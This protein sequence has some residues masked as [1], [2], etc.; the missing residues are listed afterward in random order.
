MV[1]TKQYRGFT[2]HFGP[3]VAGKNGKICRRKHW[4]RWDNFLL[5]LQNLFSPVSFEM[6]FQTKISEDM[7]KI[8]QG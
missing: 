4:K 7:T 3:N 5:S 2:V 1:C 8:I 6:K